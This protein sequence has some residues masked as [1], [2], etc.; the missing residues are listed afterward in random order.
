[1]IK[2]VNVDFRYQATTQPSPV[3]YSINI[4]NASVVLSGS[5]IVSS[6]SLINH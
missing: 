2:I 5:V 4:H 1:M 3:Q 6:L